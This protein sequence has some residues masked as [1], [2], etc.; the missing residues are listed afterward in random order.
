MNKLSPKNQ[1]IPSTNNVRAILA[2]Y[3]LP[4]MRFEYAA[5]GIENLAF[6]VW[7]DR[8]KYVL[9]VYPQHKKSNV[10]IL[11]ALDFM[12]YLKKKSL[13]VLATISTSDNPSLLVFEYDNKKWQSVLY[14]VYPQARP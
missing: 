13:P 5:S 3:N 1:F 12:A 9:R 14:D 4:L 6:I 7:S 8:K 11:L 10:D 2:H